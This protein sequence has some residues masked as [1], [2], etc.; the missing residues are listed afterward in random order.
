MR[1]GLSL[2]S[3]A[4]LFRRH[5]SRI[6]LGFIFLLIFLYLTTFTAFS[7]R[8]HDA[9]LTT[10]FDLGIYDQAIWNSLH[11]RI[12]RST[13]E[14]GF[15]IL[16]ADHVQPILLLISP[17]YLI[18]SSPRTLLLLQTVVISLGALPLFG[19]ARKRLGG[20]L[21]PLLLSAAYLLFPALE[22][23]NTFD[24][25]PVA[26]VPTLILT[27]FYFLERGNRGIFLAFA[28]LAMACKEDIS[29]PLF[30]VGLYL[31]FIR[32]QRRTGL[33]LTLL[34][35]LW[36]YIAWF[37][38]IG[39]FSP[40][41]VSIY[42]AER[43]SYLGRNLPEMVKT[44]LT[45]PQ[46]V[47]QNLFTR[48][49][50][51]YV[52]GLLAPLG[53]TSL[54]SPEVLLLSSPSLAINLL[55][56]SWL[57]H[58][59]GLFLHYSSAIVPFLTLSSLYG[60]EWAGRWLKGRWPQ[61]ATGLLCGLVLL[62][63][64]IYHRYYGLSPLAEGF[65][66]PPVG[67]HQRA[68]EEMAGLIPPEATVS[69]SPYL[70]PHVSQ[71]E[72]IYVFPN[73]HEARYIFIDTLPTNIP[74]ITRD[75]YHLVWGLIEEGGY[76]IRAS[77]DGLLLLERGL[78]EKHLSPDFYTFAS[79]DEKEIEYPMAVDFGGS[80]E[81]LGFSVVAERRAF[82]HIYLDLL[83]RLPEPIDRDLRIFTFLIDPEGEIV[84]GTDFEVAAPVW[85]PTSQWPAGRVIKS[86]TL[87]WAIE[88]GGEFGVAIGVIDG[89]NQ[90]DLERRLPPQVEECSLPLKILHG[91]T[92]LGLGTIWSNGR[93]V[94]L[95]AP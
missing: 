80:L 60:L 54:L 77:K 39:H 72:T 52:R 40:Q 93:R 73:I 82:L 10:A 18:Y 90:W 33:L 46:I 26:L 94:R 84:S 50:L 29:L 66:W 56:Q 45:H 42:Y 15:D 57:M 32:R 7:L 24:F 4:D 47:A 95:L 23:S 21:L 12:L 63:S 35:A 28:L 85:Y 89:E 16:L 51:A 38:I 1:K 48:D 88:R 69:A 11:G 92:L 49:R 14:E 34:A 79:G 86:Q 43:Y 64:L 53:F 30:L 8:R 59:E 22:S 70:N 91:D 36:F 65:I 31:V 74:I 71:R 78:S 41:G 81:F 75:F 13:N 20:S 25:H 67:E 87:H 83:W 9:F 44:A 68:A 5:R 61:M 6:A 76:G 3:M 37:V 17:L 62:S 2:H 55:S 19:L 27:A 58:R